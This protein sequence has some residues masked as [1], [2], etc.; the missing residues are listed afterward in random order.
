M[1][2]LMRLNAEKGTARKADVHGYFGGKTGTAEKVINGRYA[3]KPML[4]D[5]MAVLPADKPRYRS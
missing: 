1:R 3:K 4:T 2:F 5:F